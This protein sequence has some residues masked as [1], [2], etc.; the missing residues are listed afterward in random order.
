MDWLLALDIR[1]AGT[2]RRPDRHQERVLIVYSA[3]ASYLVPQIGAP[4]ALKCTKLH[5]IVPVAAAA[6][7]AATL[8]SSIFFRFSDFRSPVIIF[9]IEDIFVPRGPRG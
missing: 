7:A 5:S 9:S 3:A 4:K 2:T 6:A 1:H 8:E